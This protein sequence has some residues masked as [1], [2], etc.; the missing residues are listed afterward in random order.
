MKTITI[1][2]NCR[3]FTFICNSRSTRHGFAH[4]CELYIDGHRIR[5]AHCYYL[6][7][8]W[9]RFTYESV[10]LKVLNFEIDE[11]I[12]YLTGKFKYENGYVRM[13]EK[14]EELLQPVLKQDQYL[15]TV[16][17]VKKHVQNTLY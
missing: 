2:K 12:D 3:E 10:I 15:N 4:D 8:T 7:R 5:K 11:R 17:S 14:R 13:T 9:E 6:N 1:E 16:N